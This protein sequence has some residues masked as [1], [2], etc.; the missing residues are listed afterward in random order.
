[1][2]ACAASPNEAPST[3]PLD[4]SDGGVASVPRALAS[5]SLLGTS[6]RN[7]LLDPFVT[8][9]LSWG[10]FVGL[11]LPGVGTR[12]DIAI[13]KRAFISQAPAGV[14]APVAS[15]GPTGAFDQASTGV[16]LIAPIP[17]GA[18]LFHASVWVA[19]TD[20]SGAPVEDSAFAKAI[21]AT[22][23]PNDEPRE[24]YPL[25]RTADAPLVLA[26]RRWVKLALPR[27]V[28]MPEGGWFSIAITSRSL[29]VDLQAPEVVPASAPEPPAPA[30]TAVRTADERAALRAYVEVTRR[31]PE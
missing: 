12:F 23:L 25:A 17:G 18:C 20:P 31:R 27:P 5:R 26:G 7:L 2:S 30:I 21:A 22:L 10:H 15:V 3:T 24:A 28:P 1:L 8:P 29:A 13:P 19:A 9:D 11:L 16:Q 14:A 4:R 6:T